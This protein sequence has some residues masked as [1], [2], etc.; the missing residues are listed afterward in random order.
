MRLF[1]EAADLDWS[2]Q[3][4]NTD[5]K[6]RLHDIRAG[7]GKFFQHN[8]VFEIKENQLKGRSWFYLIQA[9]FDETDVLVKIDRFARLRK[10]EN[11]QNSEFAERINQLL[12]DQFFLDVIRGYNI[13][14][15]NNFQEHYAFPLHSSDKT[16]C[17]P[18]TKMEYDYF[19]Y[20][21]VNYYKDGAKEGWG[22]REPVI[23]AWINCL[24]SI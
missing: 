12:I 24:L 5:F 22:L 13:N 8:I 10:Y 15:N 7:K 17:N 9:I 11:V 16:T 6:L 14:G 23:T 1:K 3:N 18:L 19:P 2:Y 4:L 20:L 21:S